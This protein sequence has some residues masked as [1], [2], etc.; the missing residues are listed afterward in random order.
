MKNIFDDLLKGGDADK[1]AENP[2]ADGK[3]PSIDT[4]S[5]DADKIAENPWANVKSDF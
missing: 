3:G 2:W 5:G 4:P 1:I